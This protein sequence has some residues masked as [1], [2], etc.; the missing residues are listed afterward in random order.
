MLATSKLQRRVSELLS[1]FLGK[2]DIRENTRPQWL[3]T[4]D[5]ARLEL[6]FYI[7]ELGIAI[8]VQGI[9]HYAY[10]PMFHE[11][12]EDFLRQKAR[13]EFK[14]SVCAQRGIR[15]IETDCEQ[16]ILLKL[17]E[18]IPHDEAEPKAPVRSLQETT[19]PKIRYATKLDVLQSKHLSCKLKYDRMIRRE[20]GRLNRQDRIAM[21]EGRKQTKLEK[22]R[23]RI[24]SLPSEKVPL[25][26]PFCF[27]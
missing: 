14:R 11:S 9:Q 8:E 17:E 22:I 20:K 12:Y 3:V 10:T 2:Y 5:G 4:E 13:D 1:I 21:L 15:L 25:T 26:E 7:K 19:G 27:R 18:L 6:D 23:A 16:D 24:A